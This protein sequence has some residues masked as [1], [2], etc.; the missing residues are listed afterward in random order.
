MFLLLSKAVH[1]YLRIRVD[2]IK[3]QL[4]ISTEMIDH[5]YISF[6]KCF[7]FMYMDVC[8]RVCKCT[9]CMAGALRDSI[10]AP[11]TEVMNCYELLY[12]AESRFSARTNGR[13]P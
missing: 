10:R 4:L 13:C 1:E 2:K 8:L 5:I 6:V 11:G 7:Y 12:G 3:H 9:E